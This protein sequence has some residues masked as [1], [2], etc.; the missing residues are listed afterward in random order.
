MKKKKKPK[1]NVLNSNKGRIKKR[2]RKP[3][4]ID[5]KKRIRRK[6]FGACPKVGYG[7]AKSQRGVH[8][9]GLKEKLV[10]N[11]TDVL[12]ISEN[13]TEKFAI[14]ISGKVSKKNKEI[15]RKKAQELK[16]TVLN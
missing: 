5:N 2:W 16:I 7:N 13:K 3:R 9:L 12:K 10:C 1:F 4:G 15:I 8:P 11:I 14:R 6:D